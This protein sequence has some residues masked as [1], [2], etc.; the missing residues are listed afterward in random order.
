[1]LPHMNLLIKPASG[2]CNLQ[3][4]YCF[5]YDEMKKRETPAYSM[6]QADVLRIITQKALEAAGQSCSFGFQ[7]GEPTLAGLDFYKQA[8][9]YQ[10]Q[11]NVNNVPIYNAI[12]TNGTLIDDEWASFFADNRFLV[13]LSLDGYESLHDLYRKDSAGNGTFKRVM[14][15][16]ELF[17]KH[18]VDFNVLTVVTAQTA[19]NTKEMYAFF[20]R[21]G[22]ANQ[23]YIP[24][25]DP[26]EEARGNSRYSLT[27]ELYARFLKNLFDLWYE[28]RLAGNYV[29][30]RY[31]ENLA[32]MMLGHPP[33]SCAMAGK[34]SVQYAIE[35]CGDVFPCD[36]YMMDAYKLG[37]IMS[38]SFQSMD[39][40]RTSLG[41]IEEAPGRYGQCRTC[42]WFYFCRNGCKREREFL[43]TTSDRRINYFCAAYKEFFPYALPRLKKCLTSIRDVH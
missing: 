25:L 27:P 31:F 33:E 22:L 12:Q 10:R 20:M 40:N 6:M 18:N 37:N 23:Q 29:Y 15:A 16:V 2:R 43:D 8:I 13:G 9:D 24:C 30:I 19:K 34:C 36:F 7:G 32:G 35:A 1:M 28:D 4:G 41:F 5:Y 42:E 17:K 38:D 14:H 21:Q 26:F 39:Q 3:C 11:F